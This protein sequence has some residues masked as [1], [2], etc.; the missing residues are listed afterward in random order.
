MVND[1]SP[2]RSEC[3]DESASGVLTPNVQ[4]IWT[5]RNSGIWV[6]NAEV[7]L[8]NGCEI[9]KNVEQLYGL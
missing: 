8:V 1:L 5:I 4:S 3:L 6:L 7:V 9:M 2:R